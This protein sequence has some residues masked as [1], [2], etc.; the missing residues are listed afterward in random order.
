MGVSVRRSGGAARIA[1]TDSATVR[2]V[3]EVHGA[4]CA[5][6]AE[7]RSA[8]LD[9]SGATSMDAAFAQLIVSARASFDSAGAALELIDPE[10][11]FEHVFPGTG[12]LTRG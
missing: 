3:S 7:S 5:A 11:L 10:G 6:L 1:I 8:R 4:L 9:L 2:T 12:E